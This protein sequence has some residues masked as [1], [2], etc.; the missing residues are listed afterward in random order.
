MRISEM[1]DEREMQSWIE[2]NR[3]QEERQNA[4]SFAGTAQVQLPQNQD[5]IHPPIR[6]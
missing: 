3:E 5:L 2:S 6:S 1:N 4:V